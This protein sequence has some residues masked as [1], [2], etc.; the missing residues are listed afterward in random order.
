MAGDGTQPGADANQLEVIH[1][2]TGGTYFITRSI[3]PFDTTGRPTVTTASFYIQPAVKNADADSDSYSIVQATPATWNSI[4]AGDYDQ[5]GTTKGATDITYGG[6]TVDVYA[7]WLM[8]ATGRGWIADGTW[9]LGLRSARDIANSAPTGDDDVRFKSANNT[10]T[11][12]DP[13]VDINATVEEDQ[14]GVYLL[15]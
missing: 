7:Q 5:L 10:G 15:Q 12:V 14:G 6:L 4:I 3:I 11:S 2:F 9:D 8:N 13:Y 1:R